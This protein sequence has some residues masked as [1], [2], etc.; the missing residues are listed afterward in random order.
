MEGL[1]TGLSEK[2]EITQKTPQKTHEGTQ[3][4]VQSDTKASADGKG[5]VTVRK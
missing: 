3:R 5:K 2:M 1:K 4:P